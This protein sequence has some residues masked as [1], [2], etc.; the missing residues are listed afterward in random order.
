MN[1]VRTD[2]AYYV[3]GYQKEI[4]T[5]VIECI[6]R[7]K[8]YDIVLENTC[9]YPEGGGQPADKGILDG[10]EV[11]D[12]QEKNGVV[13]HSVKQPMKVGSI[14]KGEIDWEYR[15]D[16]MQNHTAEH[17]LSGLVYQKYGF[18]NVGFHMGKDAVVV[19]FDGKL[20]EQDVCLL[21]KY[22][23]TAIMLNSPVNVYYPT[24]EELKKIDYRSKKKL[25]GTIRIVEVKEYDIC[26]CCGIHVKSTGEIGCA[27]ILSCESHKG[28]SRLCMVAGKRALHDYYIKHISAKSISH[29]LSVPVEEIANAVIKL[30]A[31]KETLQYQLNLLEKER[32]E[33]IA[34]TVEQGSKKAVFFEKVSNG[35]TMQYFANLLQQ[36]V[37][38]AAVFSGN[39]KK[40]YTYVLMSQKRD[41]RELKQKLSKILNCNGG[42]TKE[43]VQGKIEAK[44]C[45]I[46]SFFKN[47]V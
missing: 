35:K 8:G 31:E 6:A 42:G 33:K 22:V 15:F 7:N 2:I 16:L 37:D 47:N 40:G 25:E 18:H 29:T 24:E 19:D 3:D 26:A 14:V 21:D 4:E 1:I 43:M 30:K 39:D 41:V 9:F 28:G 11:F 13:Y 17:I 20:S 32:L 5:K 23:N 12:V 44:E 10:Q 45:D 46:V 27:R 36:K 38:V 34:E